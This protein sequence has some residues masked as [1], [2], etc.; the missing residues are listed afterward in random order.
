MYDVPPVGEVS[1]EEFQQLGFDRL[2]GKT[3]YFCIQS[4]HE[5]QLNVVTLLQ[6]YDWWKQRIAEAI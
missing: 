1:L 4:L 5:S 6:Y 3:L 2:K